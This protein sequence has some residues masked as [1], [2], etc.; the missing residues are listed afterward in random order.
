MLPPLSIFG[1]AVNRSQELSGA[2]DAKGTVIEI[3]QKLK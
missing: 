2:D 1:E 3:A